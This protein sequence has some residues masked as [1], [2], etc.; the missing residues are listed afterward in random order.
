MVWPTSDAL[1]DLLEHAA[2]SGSIDLWRAALEEM[3]RR[4]PAAQVHDRRVV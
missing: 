1:D 3:G 4:L 2:R